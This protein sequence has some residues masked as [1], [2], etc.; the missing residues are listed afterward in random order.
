MF[1][2]FTHR[3]QLKPVKLTAMTQASE[4]P[5][6]PRSSNTVRDVDQ[7]GELFEVFEQLRGDI[8]VFSCPCLF[9]C[10]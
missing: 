4:W 6:D 1:T 3:D 5:I 2:L 7:P 9:V 8:P 10:C